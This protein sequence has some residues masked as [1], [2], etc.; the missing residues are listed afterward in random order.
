MRCDTQRRGAT[1]WYLWTGE[2]QPDADFFLP[3]HLEHVL[4]RCPDLSRVLDLPPG[5]R[6]VYAPDHEDVWE[7]DTLFEI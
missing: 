7:D 3:W 6:F 2:L 5:S 1:G 4:D